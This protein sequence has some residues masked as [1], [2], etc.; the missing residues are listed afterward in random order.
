VR[1]AEHRGVHGA[2]LRGT[3]GE[4]TARQQV[5]LL[6]AMCSMPHGRPPLGIYHV[7]PVFIGHDPFMTSAATYFQVLLWAAGS[8]ASWQPASPQRS[9]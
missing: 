2:V 7:D 9:S 5:R 6:A 1:I 3:P 8:L 4:R